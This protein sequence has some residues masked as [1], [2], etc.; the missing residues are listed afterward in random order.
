MSLS[1]RIDRGLFQ[2]DFT[3]NNAIIGVPVG[4]SANAIRKR[5]YKISRLLHPD[6]CKAEAPQEKKLAVDLFSKLVSPAYAKLSNERDRSEYEVLLGMTAKRLLQ[7]KREPQLQAEIARELLSASNIDT[8]YQEAI[9]NLADMQYREVDKALDAIAQIS[10]LNLVY[11]LRREQ[12][13]VRQPAA[14]ASKTNKPL[15][16]RP[17]ASTAAT[18]TA[19]LAAAPVPI[20]RAEQHC[21]RAEELLQKGTLATAKRE[22]QDALKL[23]PNSSRSHA[24][25]GMIYLRQKQLPVAKVHITKAIQLDSQEPTALDARKQYEK[26]ASAGAKKASAGAAKPAS[27]KSAPPSK[28]PSKPKSDKG[29]K[30]SGG[31][32]LFGGLFGGGKK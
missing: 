8:A 10:E 19:A 3:D 6:S 5:F 25:M 23:D 24:L 12:K 31:G 30:D 15:P 18:S 32:G 9:V 7:D 17:T 13:S 26:L 27:K 20:S 14:T 29:K 11:L 2:F 1:F 21:R 28:S 16:P 4:A 22:L